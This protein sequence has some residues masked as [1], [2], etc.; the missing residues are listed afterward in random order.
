MK[1]PVC[2][3]KVPV[4]QWCENCWTIYC[5]GP[6]VEEIGLVGWLG[7]YDRP[8]LPPEICDPAID[9]MVRIVNHSEW[10][11]WSELIKYSPVSRH[12]ESIRWQFAL[13]ADWLADNDCPLQEA[14][15]RQL[16]E[17]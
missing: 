9:E 6:Y 1:C 12:T 10:G 11:R 5:K 3:G 13:F 4:S 14:A 2:G 7:D 15:V 8:A 16:L 17:K